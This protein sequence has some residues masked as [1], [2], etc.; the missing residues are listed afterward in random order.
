[1]SACQFLLP[2]AGKRCFHCLHLPFEGLDK[3]I[4]G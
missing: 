4:G 3:R 2:Q 1:M